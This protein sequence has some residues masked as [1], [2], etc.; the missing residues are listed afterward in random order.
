MAEHH[1]KYTINLFQQLLIL[2]TFKCTKNSSMQQRTNYFTS[3]KL[4]TNAGIDLKS[5]KE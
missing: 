3:S 2:E 4:N 5:I 1:K